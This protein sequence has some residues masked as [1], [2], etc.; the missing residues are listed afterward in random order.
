VQAKYSHSEN[1]AQSQFGNIP[2][3][4]Y[5]NFSMKGTDMNMTKRNG[6][7]RPLT[8]KGIT[9]KSELTQEPVEVGP[10]L[11]EEISVEELQ[12]REEYSACYTTK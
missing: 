5:I 10:V 7:F 11:I 6:L 8:M 9:V 3:L 12:A 2:W 4:E 1:I